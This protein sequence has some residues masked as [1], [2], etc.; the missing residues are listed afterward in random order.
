MHAPN[1]LVVGLLLLSTA[2]ALRSQTTYPLDFHIGIQTATTKR[3][4]SVDDIVSA[5]TSASVKGI[6][7][8]LAPPNGGGGFAGRVLEGSFPDGKL[9]LKE[10]MIFLGEDGIRVEAAYGQRSIFG[11]DSLASFTRVGLRSIIRIG[12]SGFSLNFSGS[13]YFTGDFTKNKTD[14]AARAG[15]WE[16]ETGLFFTAPKYPVF[17]QLGYRAQ[18]FSFGTQAEH[19]GGFILGTGLWLGGR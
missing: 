7:A 11:K 3:A 16:G 4:G 19:N 13:K 8:F 2:S 6:E 17:A 10:G 18:Y 14:A 12:G 9:K 1:Y 15:G 5:R